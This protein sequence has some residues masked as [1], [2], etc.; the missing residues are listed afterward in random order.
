MLERQRRT[1]DPD[2]A[3]DLVAETFARAFVQR[4]RFRGGTDCEQAARLYG[5]EEREYRDVAQA[6][7][8]TEQAALANGDPGQTDLRHARCRPAPPREGPD[9]H[10]AVKFELAKRP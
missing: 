9:P 6:L 10:T 5:I 7:G 8:I 3:V 4:R 1:F 2:V